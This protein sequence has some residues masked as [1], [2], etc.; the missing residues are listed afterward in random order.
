MENFIHESSKTFSF[1]LLAEL[2]LPAS[3]IV[4]ESGP[5]YQTE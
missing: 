3:S 1:C 4:L 5:L 2:E